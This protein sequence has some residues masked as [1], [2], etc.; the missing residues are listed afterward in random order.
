[1][2][3][4]SLKFRIV[5]DDD[6]LIVTG[7]NLDDETDSIMRMVEIEEKIKISRTRRVIK[8]YR[9]P[10]RKSSSSK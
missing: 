7:F 8:K 5:P 4:F 9:E 3:K 10:S 6:Q 2:M 1:M